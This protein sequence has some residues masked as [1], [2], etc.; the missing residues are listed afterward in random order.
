MRLFHFVKF[1]FSRK[2]GNLLCETLV[3]AFALLAEVQ[4]QLIHPRLPLV[5]IVIRSLGEEE[6][7]P[8]QGEQGCYLHGNTENALNSTSRY[9]AGYNTNHPLGG[10][11]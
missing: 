6:W 7:L 11:L 10:G 3:F 8:L 2:N 5:E 4:Q 1:P 9:P